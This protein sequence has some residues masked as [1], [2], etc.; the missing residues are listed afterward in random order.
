[1]GA[2]VCQKDFF[3][4]GEGCRFVRLAPE[5]GSGKASLVSKRQSRRQL[6]GSQPP[7]PCCILAGACSPLNLNSFGSSRLPL[8]PSARDGLSLYG[9][10]ASL[11]GVVPFS[12]GLKPFETGG[13]LLVKGIL[14]G[15]MSDVFP[16]RIGTI[17]DN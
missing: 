17:C 1:M 5:L 7:S 15:G 13:F 3:S 12:E 11:L 6:Q 8:I 14:K 10:F 4:G 16:C 9:V 2:L